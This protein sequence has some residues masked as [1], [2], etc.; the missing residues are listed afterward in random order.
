MQTFLYI[1]Y[2][3]TI[4]IVKVFIYQK[5]LILIELVERGYYWYV[6]RSNTLISRS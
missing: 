3:S 5:Y 4:I 1:L 6:L 2:L